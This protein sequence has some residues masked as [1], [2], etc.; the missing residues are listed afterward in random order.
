MSNPLVLPVAVT[1]V[2]LLLVYLRGYRKELPMDGIRIVATYRMLSPKQSRILAKVLANILIE[3][4]C[5]IDYI[6]TPDGDTVDVIV[7]YHTTEEHS[8]G[9]A[10]ANCIARI[11]RDGFHSAQ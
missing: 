2:L 7:Y 3:P 5:N 9:I 4:G 8:S 1:C 10:N 6:A 11:N